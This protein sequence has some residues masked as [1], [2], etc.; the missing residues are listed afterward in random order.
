M[1]RSRD[2]VFFWAGVTLWVAVIV[3]TWP[4]A[5]S[6]G[7]EIGY[8]E[9]ARMLVSGHVGHVANDPGV[10]VATPGGIV[11]KFPLPF[12]MLLA[13]LAALAPRAV[14]A[15]AILAAVWLA[16]TARDILASWGKSPV[17]ALLVLAHP[18]L[19]ILSRTAMADVPLA[20]ASVCAWWALRRGRAGGGAAWLALLVAL[21]PTGAVL[22]LAIVGAEVLSHWR[23]LGARDGTAWRRVGL[24]ALGSALGLAFVLATNRLDHGTFGSGY[25][26]VF[27]RIKPFS[28]SYLPRQLPT[29]L[30]TLILEPPLLLAGAWTFWRRREAGPLIV[31]GGFLAMMCVYFFADSGPSRLE[32]LALSPRLILPSVAF[33][34]VGYCAWV[35]DLSHRLLGARAFDAA[36][37]VR[38]W[39]GAVIMAAPLVVCGVASARHARLQEPMARALTVASGLADAR[40]GGVLG[41]TENAGKVGVLYHG[42]PTLFDARMNRPAVVLCNESSFSYRVAAGPSS[43]RLEGYREIGREGGY[44]VLIR[45]E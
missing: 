13:P 27:E 18:T 25:E 37:R 28:L 3:A 15:L 22:A 31:A 33:L 21:K 10:W 14:F 23:A 34:L 29:H 32:T 35:D 5:L 9:R 39:L 7:D 16:R 2:D 11:A 1:S 24:G 42:H 40:G 4:S 44:V 30:A 19:V 12:S 20:T 43:C 17:F 26:V 6:F 38:P 36:G 41:I 8:V 45:P